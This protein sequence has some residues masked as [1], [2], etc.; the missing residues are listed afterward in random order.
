MTLHSKVRGAWGKACSAKDV[1]SFTVLA[2]LPFT[3]VMVVEGQFVA[4]DPGVRGGPRGRCET[5]LG[6]STDPAK[7]PRAALESANAVDAGSVGPHGC[8]LRK[9]LRRQSLTRLP[10]P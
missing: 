4:S 1:I 7:R 10:E 2:I 9:A 5:V 3:M 6:H 8:Q